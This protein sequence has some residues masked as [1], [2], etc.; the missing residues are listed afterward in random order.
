MNSR[1]IFATGLRVMAYCIL[2]VWAI[3]ALMPLY[4]VF[5]TA[6]QLPDEVLSMPPK[7]I[8]TVVKKFIPLYLQGDKDQA[9]HILSESF[10]SVRVLFTDIGLPKWFFNSV[11]VSVTATLGILLLD[12]MAGYVFA[13]KQFPGRD[14]LF[15]IMISTMMIPGQVTLV[16]MFILVTK[17][18]IKNSLWSVILPPLAMVFG[19]FL[20][21]QFMKTIPTELIEAA[22]I[23]GAS[24]FKTYWKII[25][26]LS[27]PALATLGILTFMSVW[28]SFLWPLIVLNKSYLYTLPVGLKTLQD[29]NL[30]NYGLLMSGAAISAIPMIIVF[31]FFQRYFIKGLTL[32]GLK[33]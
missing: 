23:D 33:G 26:P 15:W 3:I 11:L 1:K 20:M 8:P 32:G 29:K 18:G 7:L 21:R 6:L 9:L 16:P 17:L 5:T 28:N 2:I 25:I 4:W 10:K 14:F 30:V 27:K 19:V 31:L 22:R 13:K 24:E 12:S